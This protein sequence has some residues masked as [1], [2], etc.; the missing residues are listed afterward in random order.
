MN[1]LIFGGTGAMGSPLVKL[2][3]QKA[4]IYVTTRSVRD[5]YNNIRYIQGNAHE[6]TFLIQMLSMYKWDAI[7]DFLVRTEKELK[8]YIPLFLNNTKQYVFISSA[9]VYA[10]TDKPITEDTP[11][12]LDVSEDTE[13]LKTKE[14]ALVK[15]YEENL[16]LQSGKN[17]FTIV[18]PTITYNNYRLQLGVLE[19]E[20][21]LYRALHGRTIVFSNDI[22]DKLT[23]MT[24]G[25]DVAHGIASI[26][27]ESNALGEVF[28]ITYPKSLAWN[29][30]LAIYIRVLEKHLN[31]KV[32]VVFT[33][34]S[35]NLTFKGRIYQLIYC[36][37]FN[38]TFDNRKIAQY[39]DISNFTSPNIGLTECLTEF[40]KAPKFRK[41]RWDI[42]GINDRIVN[43]RTPLNEIPSLY[44]KLLYFAFRYD[45]YIL[46]YIVR[47]LNK[48]KN[49]TFNRYER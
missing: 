3:S 40:L 25:D 23:T 26:I 27:G 44:G 18:R 29:N 46:K 9:R 34:K 17:N 41:I 12:L 6:K 38:R 30:V 33:E 2:L 24:K 42:E 31:R 45:V 8:E 7:V 47:I 39:C 22:K 11:R 21:W 35:T 36:R 4:I 15:A 10:K 19:K 16:L 43:E 48:I 1:I 28:H 49:L 13:Y 37:Y 14:Y 5:S 32:P 20:S